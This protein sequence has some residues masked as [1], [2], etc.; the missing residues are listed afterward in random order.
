MIDGFPLSPQ[1]KRLWSLRDGSLR[2]GGGPTPFVAACAV[3][4]HGPLDRDRLRGAVDRAVAR[5]EILRTSFRTLPGMTLPLQVVADHGAPDWRKAELPADTGAA[6]RAA[7]RELLRAPVAVPEAAG[8]PVLGAVLAAAGP[9]DHVLVL[10]LPALCG[11]A[12][13]LAVLAGEIARAYAGTGSDEEVMQYADLAAWQNELLESEE[14]AVGREHWR[15]LEIDVPRPRLPFPEPAGRGPGFQP[16]LVPVPLSEAFRLEDL[17]QRT[18]ASPEA[19][20]RAAWQ[21]LAWRLTGEPDGVVAHAYDGRRYAELKDAVGPLARLV[22]VPQRLDG[23][24]PFAELARRTGALLEEHREW[25]EYFDWQGAVQRDEDTAGDGAP[26]AP[27]AVD[28]QVLP[29]EVR[30]GETTFAGL[31]GHACTDRATLQLTARRGEEGGL[32]L[33][34]QHDRARV[35]DADGERVAAGLAAL[36]E[37]AAAKPDVAAG[38]LE[39]LGPGERRRVLASADAAAAAEPP[40]D[41]VLHRRFLDDA[42]RRPEA[43][44]VLAAGLRVD[45]GELARRA[46]RVARHLRRAG[47]GPGD[48]V[49]VCDERSVE[50]VAAILGVLEAGAAYVPLDPGYPRQR[51]AFLLADS[52][53][54]ALLVRERLLPDLPGVEV[55]VL[56]LDE[57]AVDGGGETEGEAEGEEASPVDLGRVD[58]DLA[59]YV[60]YTSGSTGRPKGVV[61]S[62]RNLLH[63]TVARQRRYGDPGRQLLLPSFSFDSSVAGLFWTLGFGGSLVLPPEGAQRDARLL[64]RL[65]GEHEVSAFLGLPSVHALLLEEAEGDGELLAALRGSLDR[66]IV[67]GEACPAELVLHHRRVLPGVGLVNEYGPTEGTV[68]STVYDCAGWEPGDGPVPRPV[69][70]GEPVEGVATY[71]LHERL[72]PLPAGAAGELFLGGRGVARGYLGRPALTAERFLPD[73]F[74]PGGGRMYRTGDRVRLGHD[75]E[76]DFLGRR[77]EQVKIRGYRIELGELE[78]ILES[79]PGVDEAAVVVREEDGHP[80]L[81]AFLVPSAT[82]AATARRALRLEAEGRLDTADLAELPN[83]MPLVEHRRAETEFLYREIF[84]EAGYLRGGVELA[85]GACVF[86]VGANVG[87]FSLFVASRC[88]EPV[89]HAF[90]PIPPVCE[91][92][93]RNSELYGLRGGVHACGL[94]RTAGREEFTYYPNLSLMSGRFVDTADDRELV[95]TFELQKDGRGAALD[96][97]QIEEILDARLE[98]ESFA[99]DVRTLSQVMAEQGVEHIDLLK[100]DAEKSELA[101][102]Q[103]VADADWPKIRQVVLETDEESL[104]AVTGLLGERGFR[105]TVERDTAVAGGGL[106]NVFAVRDGAPPRQEPAAAPPPSLALLSPGRLLEAVQGHLAARVPEYM[107]PPDWRL[108][109]DLPRTP[110]GK[111]DRRALEAMEVRREEA[112]HVAPRTPTEETLAAI[113]AEV[114]K[115]DRVG[116][117]A[118]FFDLGGHSLVATRV[119]SRVRSALGADLPVRTLFRAPTVESLAQEVEAARRDEAAGDAPPPL[120]AVPRQGSLPLSHAQQRLWFVHQLEPD[121]AAYNVFSALTLE[122]DLDLAL[123]RRSLD[124]V[125]R[126][127][128]ILRT[129][130]RLEGDRPVQVVRP[131]APL[132]HPL[133]DLAAVQAALPAARLDGELARLAVAQGRRPFDLARGPLLRAVVVRLA[134]WRHAVLNTLHHVVADAWSMGVLVAE[135]AAHYRAFRER[136]VSDLPPPA[137]QYGDYA[138]WQRGWLT[139]D[140]L[141]RQLD[142][143]RRQLAGLT[144]LDLPADRPR[145]A[146]R[147]DRGG[148]LALS[149]PQPVVEGVRRLARDGGATEFMVLLAAFEVLLHAYTGRRDLAVGT[150]VAN[151][152]RLETEGLIGFFINQLVLRVDLS[153]DPTFRELVERVKEVALA[154]YAHQ[155]VPFERLVEELRPERDP[156]RPLLFQVKLEV[157]NAPM[158]GLDLPDLEVR[159]LTTSRQVV[160]Y[161]L[162]LALSSGEDGIGG[163]LLYSAELFDEDTARRMGEG[164]VRVLADAVEDP[165]RSLE[166]LGAAVASTESRARRSRRTDQKMKNLEKLKGFQRQPVGGAAGESAS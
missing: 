78:S 139:G 31:D 117:T 112:E 2:E 71:V 99:C 47:V 27:F 102:L 107:V 158:A 125:V 43:E 25:Q 22:P 163:S 9:D 32:V 55:P 86:D 143:W 38:E 51:L 142:Y 160:R 127:H 18:G 141:E 94:G 21:I 149:L 81:A 58:P 147:S 113:W 34:V 157:H 100:V 104:E 91:A 155:D 88:R 89:I 29:P 70:I 23:G 164:F 11:D 17:A 82:G 84:A 68:W 130:F 63:S 123:L 42:R 37:E 109:A 64:A 6:R 54:R 87:A 46:R 72:G 1:Q 35:G 95:R 30:A 33:Q 50:M 124:E 128:E 60:I 61:V 45:R 122:G 126:R 83:G 80:R 161:D 129:V 145:P 15:S 111:V 165:D 133:V 3:A 106:C 108:L 28:L 13:A 59:A 144:P 131:P 151:R 48:R 116:V 5:H 132:H 16:R 76:L 24:V 19:V 166:S 114:L 75:G 26:W 103:G 152:N 156:S 146:E 44:A 65:V 90:E 93:R 96:E 41:R 119:M 148:K 7:V 105:L 57:V 120:V 52:R 137:V 92:L 39:V 150:N 162:H 40:P 140:V 69:P 118:N 153:G 115:L 79:H 136:R 36:L 77:D 67:A 10:R 154:A 121:S 134:E 101:V 62:H 85:D 66:V 8:E 135:V 73:P 20:L 159:P 74:A 110:N 53:S 56:L 97:A 49:A 98:T 14:R 12:A 138:A 4:V